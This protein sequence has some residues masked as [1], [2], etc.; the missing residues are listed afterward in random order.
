MVLR[1]CGSILAGGSGG[2]ERRGELAGESSAEKTKLGG[3]GDDGAG[4]ESVV[5]LRGDGV[6]DGV[7]AVDEE[8]QGGGE[9]GGDEGGDAL[10]AGEAGAGVGDEELHHGADV[11]VEA[12]GDELVVCDVEALHG[13]GGDVAAAAGA[14]FDDVL[15]EVGELEAGADVVGELHEFF[16]VVAADEKDETADGVGGVARVVLESGEGLV[17]GV[18][19]VL[20]EGGDEVVEGLDGEVAG[21]DGGLE[22]DE[23]WVARG[24][25]VGEAL[26]QHGAPF[27]EE[28]GRGRGVGYFVAEVVGGAAEGV[29]AVE[30]RAQ[31]GGKEEGGYVEVFVVGGGKGLAPGLGFGERGAR[32]RREIEGWSAE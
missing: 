1:S 30:V 18:D 21:R 26:V 4:A 22:G 7:A 5:V 24:V 6:E 14:V 23:D 13:V 15:I 11:G 20:L 16:G 3:L 25:R 31:S 32:V 9:V 10:A 2:L 28:A 12:S 27:G 19:L 17:V 29:D 8:L